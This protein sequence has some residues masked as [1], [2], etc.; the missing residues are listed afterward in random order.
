MMGDGMVAMVVKVGGGGD[1]S[2]F[3]NIP[4]FFSSSE[5]VGYTIKQTKQTKTKTGNEHS[6]GMPS[7]SRSRSKGHTHTLTTELT[8]HGW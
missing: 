5:D 2:L 4:F 8:C 1:T 3:I 7:R 6:F